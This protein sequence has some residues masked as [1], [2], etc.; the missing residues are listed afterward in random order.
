[1]FAAAAVVKDKRRGIAGALL[2]RIK[3]RRAQVTRHQAGSCGFWLIK[4]FQTHRGINWE[5]I[6]RLAGRHRT[7]LVID[8][9]LAIPEDAFIKRFL[10][11]EFSLRL[12]VNTVNRAVEDS[13]IELYQRMVG[14][15]DPAGQHQKLVLELVKH[16]TTVKVFT[17]SPGRYE[18]F[19]RQMM[20]YYGV[21]VLVY[22]SAASLEDC[23]LVLSPGQSSDCKLPRDCP[24]ATAGEPAGC[25]GVQVSHLACCADEAVL[26]QLPPGMNPTYFLAALYELGRQRELGGLAAE[27]C[28]IGGRAAPADEIARLMD[29]RARSLFCI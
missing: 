7:R 4:S 18:V 11:G 3:G 15:V 12:L 21:A 20:E 13:H 16:F 27:S 17:R 23:I 8:P 25:G 22:D 9:S 26:R 10:P 19:C 2:D 1:M 6:S 14:L 24:V 29:E 5:E 28:R